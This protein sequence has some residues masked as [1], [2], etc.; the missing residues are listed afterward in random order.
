MQTINQKIVHSQ[1][2]R[3][4]HAGQ[5]LVLGIQLVPSPEYR[6]GAGGKE[7]LYAARCNPE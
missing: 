2:M 4:E 3:N 6:I 1:A 5:L 7:D